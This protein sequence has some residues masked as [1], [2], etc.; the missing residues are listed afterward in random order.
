MPDVENISSF[1]PKGSTLSL[2]SLFGQIVVL[3]NK[4][5]SNSFVISFF[6]FVVVVVFC[7]QGF[8]EKFQGHDRD[9]KQ[10]TRKGHV[11]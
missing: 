4:I 10:V 1:Y 3:S 6:F 11:C 9:A 2:F 7:L 8:L 5:V